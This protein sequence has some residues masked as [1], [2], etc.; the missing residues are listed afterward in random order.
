MDHNS[1]LMLF[2]RLFSFGFMA[3]TGFFF[4]GN[5]GWIFFVLV[6]FAI[7]TW[8]RNERSGYQCPRCNKLFF[9]EYVEVN[10]MEK[11][12]WVKNGNAKL[13][14]K[15]KQCGHEWTRFITTSS[16]LSSFLYN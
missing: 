7:A 6:L 2:S 16:V 12:G 9:R 15:C 13:T 3:F 10:V 11:E 14:Y 1:W 8:W 5:A 4:L